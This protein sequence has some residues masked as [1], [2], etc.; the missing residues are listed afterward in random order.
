MPDPR[1]ARVAPPA[2]R[3]AG[4]RVRGKLRSSCSAHLCEADTGP[5][6][7]KARPFMFPVSRRG[8]EYR[9]RNASRGGSRSG[10]RG[11]EEQPGKVSRQYCGAHRS[12]KDA[13]TCFAL[14]HRLLARLETTESVAPA[15]LPAISVAKALLAELRLTLSLR[16]HARGSWRSGHI[17]GAE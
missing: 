3:S 4:C 8:C 11:V 10:A 9:R 1:S 5:P 2:T 7:C 12:V 14:Q 15:G 16:L 6:H 17:D 13:A